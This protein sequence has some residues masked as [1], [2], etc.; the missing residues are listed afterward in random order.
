MNDL[1]F[2]NL[3]IPAIWLAAVAAL[4]VAPAIEKIVAR[5]KIGDWYWNSFFLYFIVW[6]L[7]YIIFHPGL[8]LD[9]PFSILYFNGGTK[10]HVLALAVLFVYL[11][12]LGAKKGLSIYKASA[13]LFLFYFICYE[14]IIRFSEANY[15]GA[16]SHL[17]VLAS[18]L[19][20]LRAQ[21]QKKQR[22]SGQLLILFILVEMLLIS[23]F[24][25]ILSIEAITFA[26]LGLT[27]SILNEK[28]N[29]EG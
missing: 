2:G 27:I 20:L 21:Q 11:L 5:D 22:L 26:W 28:A 18:L 9:H 16:V 1:Q 13:R 23:L 15:I 10:G 14:A 29:K 6:K 12:V 17:V 24:H 19:V 8:F 4:F 25:T 3:S 7:S